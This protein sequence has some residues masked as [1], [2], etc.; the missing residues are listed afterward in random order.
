MTAAIVINMQD[1]NGRRLGEG[2]QGRS[3]SVQTG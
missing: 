2:D 1:Q 3:P